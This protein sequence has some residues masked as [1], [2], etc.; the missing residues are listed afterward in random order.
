MAYLNCSQ[1][2]V[3]KQSKDKIY[4]QKEKNLEKRKS[5]SD[6]LQARALNNLDLIS[7]CWK[8]GLESTLVISQSAAPT[9]DP[10]CHG[11]DDGGP[12]IPGPQVFLPWAASS[13]C[14]ICIHV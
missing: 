10:E 14:P 13:L 9:T 6:H 1:E 5:V 11:L 7:F 4:N 3:W 12:E 2:N 8:N